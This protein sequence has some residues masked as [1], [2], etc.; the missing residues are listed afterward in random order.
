MLLKT[1]QTVKRLVG[2][3]V[4]VSGDDLIYPCP[5]CNERKGHLY[6]NPRLGIFHCFYC[7][8]SGRVTDV[9]GI[10]VRSVTQPLRFVKGRTLNVKVR[11][12]SETEPDL[13]RSLLRVKDLRELLRSHGLK[14]STLSKFDV[15]WTFDKLFFPVYDRGELV[16]GQWR[17]WSEKRYVSVGK[18]KQYL[19]GW[20]VFTEP[21][22]AVICEGCFD[23][24][25]VWQD[26]G[27]Y[28]FATFGASLTPEQQIRIAR[29]KEVYVGWDRDVTLK[30]PKALRPFLSMS[31]DGVRVYRVLWPKKDPAECS[32]EEIL[33]SLNQAR[34]L[35]PK[36]ILEE[37]QKIR[38]GG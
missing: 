36:V 37:V 27:L 35:T 29:L 21:V 4:R 24:M 30:N 11:K 7:N 22:V 17:Y 3:P 25:R 34:K 10:E 28:A 12:F 20:H 38:N 26:T 13:L 31:W 15:A 23:A 6:V 9:S 33:E 19:F 2:S 16:A 8:V 14:L 32:K 18:V 5:F 1:G